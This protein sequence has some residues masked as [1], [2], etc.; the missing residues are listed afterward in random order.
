MVFY[1]YRYLILFG[2]GSALYIQKQLLSMVSAD[3]CDETYPLNVAET[4]EA[5]SNFDN[6]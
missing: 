5:C 4:R 3:L 1:V 6:Q 2:T